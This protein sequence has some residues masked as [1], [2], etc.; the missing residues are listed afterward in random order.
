MLSLVERLEIATIVS[1]SVVP[2]GGSLKA[3]PIES[4]TPIRTPGILRRKTDRP[5]PEVRSFSAIVRKLGFKSSLQ[6]TA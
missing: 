3:I 4:P 5:S 6:K 2:H 1:G